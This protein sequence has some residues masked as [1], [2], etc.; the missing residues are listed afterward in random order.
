[1]Q[2]HSIAA[3]DAPALG[4][5]TFCLWM[6]EKETRLA[7]YFYPRVKWFYYGR[8]KH[9]IS[10]RV[11]AQNYRHKD[12]M[13]QCTLLRLAFRNNGS[14]TSTRGGAAGQTQEQH[15]LLA[16]RSQICS[17][18]KRKLMIA[19]AARRESE[20]SKLPGSKDASCTSPSTLPMPT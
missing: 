6:G 16:G 13:L 14:L 10:H 11:E 17:I 9:F 4:R 19:S 5:L 8:N 3:C 18:L 1:M 2:R 12:Q 20:H 7:N 15:R